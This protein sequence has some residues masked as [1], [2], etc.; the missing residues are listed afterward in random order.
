MKCKRGGDV[1]EFLDNL[2][3]RRHEL[4]A[5]GVVIT[6]IEYE[7]TVLRGIP[8]HFATFASQMLTSLQIVSEYTKEPVDTEQLCRSISDEA[9]RI[10]TRR[11]LKEQA[12]NK[13]KKGGQTDQALAATSTSE[14][15]N[16]YNNRKRRRKG[17][18]HH[19]GREG[20]WVR[21][22]RTKKKE[23]AVAAANNSSGQTAQASAGNTSKP[24]NRPGSINIVP[25]HDSDDEGFWVVEEEVVHA[26]VDCA[27][28]GPLSND[29]ESDNEGEKP[30]TEETVAV[31]IIPAGED[32]TPRIEIYDTGA[33][34]HISPYKADFTSYVPLS[35]PIYLNSANNSKFP[36]LGTGTLV[37]KTL[38]DGHE[39]KLV[40]HNVL[41]A[42]AVGYTLVS[43][44]LLDKGGYKYNVDNGV[45]R[46]LSP[47]REPIADI[48]RN[49]Y[50]L[51]KV[52]HSPESVHTVELMSAM[53]LHHR[54]GHISVASS[55]QLVQSGTVKGIKLDPN[56]PETD[57]EACI[58]ARATRLPVSIQATR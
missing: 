15:G 29:S 19:C 51:Y 1:R 35:S 45:L 43:L 4:E 42:P 49:P 52:I 18:C 32:T 27:E 39:S 41:Y 56:T 48:P 5:I 55:R 53:E 44:G 58:F 20:H 12:Q 54:L 28:P 31:I 38:V 2:D 10:K 30:D 14:S 57:C 22:C 40:L 33:T 50:N 36:A 9:D 24:K 46:L 7:R 37:V 25:V 34:R 8:D 16:N 23:E 6:D 3:T 21:E 17:K 13:G 11:T 26:H 47:R